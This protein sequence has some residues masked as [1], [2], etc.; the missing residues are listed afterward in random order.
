MKTTYLSLALL[1]FCS[2]A[3][4][5]L[6]VDAPLSFG[7]IA[8]RNN[9]SVSTVSINRNGNQ[10]STNQIYIV[11]PGTPGVYTITGLSPYTQVNLSVDLPAYSN[12]S[13]PNTAQFQF[14]AVDMPNSLNLGPSGSAQFRMGGT[15]ST[16]GNSRNYYS[17]AKYTIYL[18]LNIDY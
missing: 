10:I 2:S 3:T 14:T 15:L 17:G 18:N 12:E 1:L 9:N 16:S 11:K 5:D 13:Y 8:I 4:A 7:E 6:V